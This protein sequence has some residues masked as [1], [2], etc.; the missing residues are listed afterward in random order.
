MKPAAALIMPL[1]V[2]LFMVP[3]FEK[4]M[5]FTRRYNILMAP[6]RQIAKMTGRE[7]ARPAAPV[8]VTIGRLSCQYPVMR[9][10]LGIKKADPNG[11]QLAPD[12]HAVSGIML[13]RIPFLAGDVSKSYNCAWNLLRPFSEV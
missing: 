5:R 9:P 10:M 8:T 2:C 11:P 13:M 1:I 7:R 6:N 12:L 4:T 3:Y